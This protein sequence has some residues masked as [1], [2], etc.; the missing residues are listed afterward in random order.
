MVELRFFMDYF[1]DSSTYAGNL[2]LQG[3]DYPF[4]YP[5]YIEDLVV[6]GEEIHEGW[7]YYSLLN[8]ETQM[9]PRYPYYRLYNAVDNGCDG[10]GEVILRGLQL[11]EST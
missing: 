9:G 4:L 5:E 2:V 7:N 11:I 1:P 10:I 6:V 8:E 3:S